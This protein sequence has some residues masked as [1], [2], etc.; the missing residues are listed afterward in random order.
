MN[1]EIKRLLACSNKGEWNQVF[2][3]RVSSAVHFNA[4]EIMEDNIDKLREEYYAFVNRI[5]H[6]ESGEKQAIG[7]DYYSDYQPFYYYFTKGNK[8]KDKIILDSLEAVM[9]LVS[10]GLNYWDLHCFN[11]IT[12]QDGNIKLVDLD[13]TKGNKPKPEN[14]L[15]VFLELIVES[16]FFFDI[17]RSA[18]NTICG[19]NSTLRSMIPLDKYYSPR[20]IDLIQ[21]TYQKVSLFKDIELILK[22]F[23]DEEKNTEIRNKIRSISPYWY[24]L[25][26]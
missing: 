22:E 16:Y 24:N 20:L 11:I 17:K 13:G 19:F 21:G 8:N 2:I 9:A 12:N 18:S 14:I 10:L 25:S 6:D 23:E 4:I 15:E 26:E 1:D 3:K 5:Y 7:S